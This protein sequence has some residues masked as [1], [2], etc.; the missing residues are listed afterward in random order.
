MMEF[1]PDAERHP[2][3]RCE[4]GRVWTEGG[5]PAGNFCTH[6]DITSQR[7]LRYGLYFA[8]KRLHKRCPRKE[9]KEVQQA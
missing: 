4:Y 7:G 9:E 5:K 2:C 1:N 3:M 8:T 6:P